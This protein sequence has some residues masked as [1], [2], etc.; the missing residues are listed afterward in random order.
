M[1]KISSLPKPV[2]I[3]AGIDNDRI[4]LT[5]PYNGDIFVTSVNDSGE[6]FK[7]IAQIIEKQKVY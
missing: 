2:R 7:R 5:K 3:W 1:G 6:S 4:V